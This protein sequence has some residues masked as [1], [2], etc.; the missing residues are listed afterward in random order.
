MAQ[1]DFFL[2]IDGIP[3][4]S[5]DAKHSNE[6]DVDSWSWGETNTG[7]AGSRGGLGAGKVQMQDFNF[8]MKVNKASPKLFEAC[9][10][11]SHIK[12]AILTCRKAGGDQQEYMKY[13]FTT[14]LV[15]SYMTGGSDGGV[16]PMDQISLNFAKV[17]VEYKEQKAD[18][19]LG[20]AT[21]AGYDLAANKKV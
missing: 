21:K 7:D 10:T 5:K 17:E 14:L 8:T 6:I 11:G 15:S 20:G 2:K 1:V 19:T 9:A 13:T 3:G 18:G 4:E 12:S 16:I